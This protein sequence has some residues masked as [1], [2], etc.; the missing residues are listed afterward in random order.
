MTIVTQHVYPP[1]ADRSCDW[2]AYDDDTYEPGGPV[3][4]GATEEEALAALKEALAQ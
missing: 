2:C 1:V 3:G 4:W